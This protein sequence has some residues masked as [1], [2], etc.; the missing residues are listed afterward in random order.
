MGW[1]WCWGGLGVDTQISFVS[2][3]DELLSRSKAGS[4][5]RAAESKGCEEA[6]LLLVAVQ[7]KIQQQLGSPI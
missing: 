5:I 7:R 2:F 6:F 3:V 4:V 1:W